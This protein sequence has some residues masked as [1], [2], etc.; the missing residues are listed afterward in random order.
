MKSIRCSKEIK[1]L[2]ARLMSG[3]VVQHQHVDLTNL[4]SVATAPRF[5]TFGPVARIGFAHLCLESDR[6]NSCGNRLVWI[7]PLHDF[8]G[9]PPA[10]LMPS[11]AQNLLVAL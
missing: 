8:K 11:P 3:F 9:E 5:L 10:S 6:F 4:F 7:V 2:R 1:A